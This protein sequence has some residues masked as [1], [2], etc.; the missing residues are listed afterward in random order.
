RGPFSSLTK[1]ILSHRR[2]YYPTRANHPQD[3]GN[4]LSQQLLR[5]RL[6]SRIES[7]QNEQAGRRIRP[8]C[9]DFDEAMSDSEFCL[10]T[11]ERVDIEKIDR[12]KHHILPA[13]DRCCCESIY[14]PALS[15]TRLAD[16]QE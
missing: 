6:P 5:F 3:S 9:K 16:Q 8:I 7:V 4:D 15:R 2:D 1:I 14:K 12:Q 11:G 10:E 13:R